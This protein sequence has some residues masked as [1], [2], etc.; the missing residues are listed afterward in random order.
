MVTSLITVAEMTE[1]GWR[2]GLGDPTVFGYLTTAAYF[3]AAAACWVAWRRER[4]AA[5]LIPASPLRPAFWLVLAVAMAVLGVNKQLDLQSLF[6]QIGR[7]AAQRGGWY[8]QRRTVQAAFIAG[9][10]AAGLGAG[11]AMLWMVRR[12]W[13]RYGLALLGTVYLGVF[14]V[15]RAA[16]FHHVDA[17]LYTLP[18]A[19]PM[20]NRALELGG[21]A[22]VGA[23]AW[24]ARRLET[25][26]W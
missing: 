21:I 23:C 7:E 6:T 13:R 1:R 12:S 14:I 4:L 22:L 9:L 11:G 16:S 10:G 20:V 18:I 26:G 19:G 17:A 5:R 8:E 2:P 3:A 25:A 24:R 15:V